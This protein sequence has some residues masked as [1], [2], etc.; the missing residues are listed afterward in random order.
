MEMRQPEKAKPWHRLQNASIGSTLAF[1]SV[2]SAGEDVMLFFVGWPR[3]RA[4]GDAVCDALGIASKEE[5]KEEARAHKVLMLSTAQT[6]RITPAR[7]SCY[8]PIFDSS[9]LWRIPDAS[10]LVM[11]QCDGAENLKKPKKSLADG[12]PADKVECKR[13][14]RDI[15]SVTAWGGRNGRQEESEAD[16]LISS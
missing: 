3:V 16:D 10:M 9:L 5:E 4:V 15:G 8:A 6:P 2:V 14:D 1:C 11:S 13:S 7:T 12:A